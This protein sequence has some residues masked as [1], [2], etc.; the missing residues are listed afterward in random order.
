MRFE[1]K[2]QKEELIK[3]FEDRAKEL[4]KKKKEDPKTDK[5][6]NCKI[7]LD[8]RCEYDEI[9]RDELTGEIKSCNGDI[10][11]FMFKQPSLFDAVKILDG[12]DPSK[13]YGKFLLAWDCMIIKEE[14]TPEV[15]TD[16]IKLGYLTKMLGHIDALMGDQKKS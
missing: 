12:G 2:E 8:F 3:Q 9:E 7:V 14:S 15:F 10:H 13:V 4:E 11:F 5:N 6:Y 1:S 16:R